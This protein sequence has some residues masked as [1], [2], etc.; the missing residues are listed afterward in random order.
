MINPLYRGMAVNCQVTYID[1]LVEV[2]GRLLIVMDAITS[3]IKSGIFIIRM[4]MQ[5]SLSNDEASTKMSV[6]R[7]QGQ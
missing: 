5:V 1:P 6:A 3:D 4:F 2:D 7:T